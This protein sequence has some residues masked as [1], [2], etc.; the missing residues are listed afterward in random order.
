MYSIMHLSVQPGA[1]VKK[2]LIEA[3]IGEDVYGSYDAGI[4]QPVFSIVAK[5]ANVSDAEKFNEIITDTLKE[6]VKNGINKEALLAGININEFKFREADFGQ[7]PKG[8][9]F[10]LNCMDSWLFDDLKPFIH[11]ECLDTFAKLR[12]KI[13]TGY[14]EELI[15]KYLLDNTHGSEVVVKP[16]RNKNA[17]EEQ[18]LAD[19]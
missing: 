12:D 13:N 17:Q 6:I 15:Q 5:N 3:G 11:L 2:A 18:K 16:A 7:F 4:L 1:P 9:L 8:L 14:F 10:G 19:K